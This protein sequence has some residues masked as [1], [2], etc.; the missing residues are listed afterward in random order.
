MKSRTPR[1]TNDS[2]LFTKLFTEISILDIR[3]ALLDR[4]ITSQTLFHLKYIC[5]HC[6][7]SIK[8]SRVLWARHSVRR[9]VAILSFLTGFKACH[10]LT[11]T[12]LDM[13]DFFISNTKVYFKL[14]KPKAP[15]IQ[16][17]VYVLMRSD[18]SQLSQVCLHGRPA[19]GVM[20]QACAL[21]FPPA[22][23]PPLQS[24]EKRFKR[25]VYGN[26]LSF[27]NKFSG[28]NC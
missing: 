10:W 26:P 18:Y 28:L 19:E 17:A 9:I 5:P 11:V 22:G 4:R 2:S 15:E 7:P 8:T 6:M 1:M 24:H 13:L 14:L 16:L 23:V 21:L 12:S 20:N 27:P 3:R 25:G